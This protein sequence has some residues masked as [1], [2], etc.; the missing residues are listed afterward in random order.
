MNTFAF[1]F[2]NSLLKCKEKWVGRASSQHKPGLPL[3]LRTPVHVVQQALLFPLQRHH[4]GGKGSAASDAASGPGPGYQV[5]P[6]AGR[7]VHH[8]IQDH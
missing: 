2:L 3:L 7:S 1:W 4:G 6:Q 8:R 5:G